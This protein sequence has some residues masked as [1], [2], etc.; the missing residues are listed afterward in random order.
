MSQ[1]ADPKIIGIFVAGAV[2]LAVAALLVFGSR[3]I[4]GTKETF[5]VFFEES[6]RGLGVGAPVAFRGV[7]IGQVSEILLH[8]DPRAEKV[9][10]PVLI[11][12][13][14]EQIGVGDRAL[15]IEDELLNQWIEQGLR[16]QLTIQS[17]VTGQLMVELDF[18]P[19]TPIKLVGAIAEHREIPTVPTD[20]EKFFKRFE[21]APIERILA[22]L[23]S[24]LAA[25][26]EVMSSP[27]LKGALKGLNETLSESRQLVQTLNQKAEPAAANLEETLAEITE[28][29]RRLDAR[30]ASLSRELEAFLAESRGLVKDVDARIGPL[31][32]NL[33]QS[34]AETRETMESLGHLV[35]EDSPVVQALTQS[36]EDFSEAARALRVL[37]EY[38][39][40]HPEALIHGKG[41]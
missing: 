37:A 30:S 40:H 6:V 22:N 18:H 27:E 13:D 2:V 1:K 3:Q 36:L 38:L 31:S 29:V 10:I 26:Q 5:V 17:L 35:D 8:I 12:I 20:L 28:F 39:E 4:F 25:L 14:P 15:R 23:E 24:T 41:D 21:E 34:S 33:E 7:Q 19:R 16:A 9:R 11:E 32:S